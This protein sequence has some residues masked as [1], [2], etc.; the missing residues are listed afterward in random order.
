[1]RSRG[2]SSLWISYETLFTALRSSESLVPCAIS[3]TCA[4]SHAASTVRLERRGRMSWRKALKLN[5]LARPA[6]QLS[7]GSSLLGPLSNVRT[8]REHQS[9]HI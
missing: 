3:A 5:L 7:A 1:M 6:V 8:S 9:F 2:R 4:Y